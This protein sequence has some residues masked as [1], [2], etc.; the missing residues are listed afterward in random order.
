MSQDLNVEQGLGKGPFTL[1]VGD[2]EFKVDSLKKLDFKYLTPEKKQASLKQTSPRLYNLYM[3]MLRLTS[4]RGFDDSAN[5]DMNDL[6]D[7]FNAEAK[8]KGI[9]LRAS[10]ELQCSLVVSGLEG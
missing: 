8:E 2:R 7:Q 3:A 6:I 10:K 9:P 5:Q 4:E 1:V